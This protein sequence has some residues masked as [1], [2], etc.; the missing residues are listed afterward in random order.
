MSLLM[1]LS[2]Y[3]DLFWHIC[4]V[5]ATFTGLLKTAHRFSER[6]ITELRPPDRDGGWDTIRCVC[7]CV[8]TDYR[9][10]TS[11]L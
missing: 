2:I 10:A 1:S 11:G 5:F 8:E 6:Q 4:R 7:V 9:V 3:I